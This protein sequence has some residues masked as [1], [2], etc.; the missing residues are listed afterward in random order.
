MPST[1]RRARS[2]RRV[3][4]LVA[5]A[6]ALSFVPVVASGPSVG[7]AAASG[8]TPITP[9]RVVDTRTGLGAVRFEAGS[10]Q[11]ID[12]ST[13][14]PAGATA[15]SL[16]VTATEPTASTYVTVWPTGAPR[17]GTSNLNVIA[18]QTRPNAVMVGLGAGR[19]VSLYNNTGSVQLIVDVM[20]WTTSGFTGMQ[21]VR[22]LDTRIGLGAARMGPQTSIDLPVAGRSGVPA[23]AAAV[24]LNLT[25]TEPTAASYLTVWPSGTAR[26]ATSN[27]NVAAGETAANLVVVGVG[28]GGAVSLFNLAGGVQVIA[29]VMGW[30][31]SSGVFA[32]LSTPSRLLDTRGGT[33]GFVLGPGESRTITVAKGGAVAA[34]ALNVTAVSVSA[35]TYLT[36]W[37]AGT[38]RPTASSVNAVPGEQA[39][40]NLVTVGVGTAGQVTLFNLAG[41]VEVVVDLLGSFAGVTPS[42]AAVACPAGAAPSGGAT[43]FVRE[44]AL[45]NAVGADRAAVWVCRVPTATVDAEYLS[46]GPQRLQ[47]TPQSAAAVANTSVSPYF[48][49]ISKGRYTISFE[50]VGYID[51]ANDE[52]PGDCLD[53]A[54]SQTGA[55]FTNVLAVDNSDYG[56][57]F[58]GPGFISSSAGRSGRH[59]LD[60]PQVTG[61]GAWVGGASVS[62]YPSQLVIAHE[63]GHTLHWPHSYLDPNDEYDNPV[64]LMSGEP[65]GAWCQV[66]RVGYP[67]K[68]QQT[69]AFNRLAAGWID[70]NETVVHRSGTTT[71][72]LA[73]PQQAGVQILT[74]VGPNTPDVLV[75]LEA[76]PRVGYDAV[77]DT[78]GVAVHLVDMRSSRCDWPVG[79]A[80]VSLG[81]RQGQAL[82]RPGSTD[83]VVAVGSQVSVAGLTIRVDRAVGTS[84]QVTVSGTFDVGRV[85]LAA[86]TLRPTM[87]TTAVGDDG[88][89]YRIV[90]E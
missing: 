45:Q 79:G 33:C 20:G 38:T 73:A 11:T 85:S 7:A 66:G 63:I 48:A 53:R 29:D 35:N 32:A 54:Q 52:G 50:A 51:L 78:A 84:Y 4:R 56:G 3:A 61:R 9:T 10:V 58:A 75:T 89:T 46:F 87:A 13:I 80:C 68:A 67:C 43:A 44:A 70:D 26:P 8:F 21:P 81:R 14:A 6:L 60:P 23:N 62:V 34:V 1:D 28:A 59:L 27:L 49:S 64:D 41:T 25:A 57:G 37:Q 69:L 90:Q 88:D 31:D 86:A 47:V 15:V 24:V 72:L 71:A 5:C 2:H 55:P 42:G 65:D 18:G 16:N 12:L 19:S 74:A 83:H 82:G 40:S 30:F 17:P 39:T 22:V 36:V 76:R 77:L